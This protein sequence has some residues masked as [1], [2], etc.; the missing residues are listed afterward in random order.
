MEKDDPALTIS[1]P[2]LIACVYF[3]MLSVAATILINGFLTLMGVDE[4][5]PLFQSVLI[6]VFIAG[7]TGALFGEAIICCPKPYGYRVFWL[8][9]I[10]VI[11]SLPFFAL[12]LTAGMIYEKTAFMPI[13]GWLSMLSFYWVVLAYSYVLFGWAMALASGLAALYL[14][15]KL[16]YDILHMYE[17]SPVEKQVLPLKITKSTKH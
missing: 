7:I 12:G 6:G 15:G 13:N 9:F 11:A 4:L 5:I 14:R 2:R 17:E 1:S 8:G 10:M 16:V 3:A